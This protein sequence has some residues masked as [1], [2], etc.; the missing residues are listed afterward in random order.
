M[1]PKFLI[2]KPTDRVINVGPT[3]SGKSILAEFLLSYVTA[4]FRANV[5]IVDPKHGWFYRKVDSRK[6][7]TGYI[8]KYKQPIYVAEDLDELEEAMD[9]QRETSYQ[10]L[11]RPPKEHLVRQNAKELD[12]VASLVFERGH[13][14]L[15][16]DELYMVANGSDFQVRAPNYFYCVTQGRSKKIG[17]W[18]SVQRPSWIPLIALTETEVRSTF[19]LRNWEDRKRMDKVL[20]DGIPWEN[21]RIHK[22]SFVQANDM[23]VTGVNRLQFNNS[24]NLS[25]K[26]IA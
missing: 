3:G 15:Y 10:I 25:V 6:N 24:Q 18:G 20:G 23:E 17:V 12:T 5:V 16:Y 13:T 21:L 19:Y 22:H 7:P 11:Y 1:E 14:T 4:E 2:P 26:R 9:E 8:N